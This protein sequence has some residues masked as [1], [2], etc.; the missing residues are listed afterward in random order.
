[1]PQQRVQGKKCR[2][3]GMRSA[4]A[5]SLI[6]LC[7][8]GRELY[9]CFAS[10]R[11]SPST[12]TPR[13]RSVRNSLILPVVL[14]SLLGIAAMATPASA[15]VAA[16]AAKPETESAAPAPDAKAAI[17]PH[18]AVY[19]LSLTSAKNGSNISDVSGRMVFEWRDVCDGWAVQQHLQLHFSYAE[20]DESTVTSSELSWESRDGKQYNFNVRRVTDDKPPEIFRGKAT[21][22]D[23]G[24]TVTYT[25]P[26]GKTAQL[27]PGTLFP[28][29]HTRMILQKAAAGE[30]L[31]TRRVFDGS[32]EQGSND[33]SVF[34]DPTQARWQDAGLPAALK[35]N[36]LMNAASWPVRMAFYNLQ[37]ETGEPD[38]EMDLN[39]LSDGIARSMRIDYGDFVVSGSL[40]AVEPLPAPSCSGAPN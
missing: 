40:A 33:V 18:R 21:M 7:H 29:S 24:G 15:G 17:T 8:I 39:L 27:P 31:F 5:G 10:R 34:I 14:I 20:G 30:K 23:Q 13:D 9:S 2:E 26:E 37:T 4:N 6:G 36:P 12:R 1:M 22:N 28:S 11:E 38:Y 35:D 19:D 16:M 3:Y 32:D 25:V